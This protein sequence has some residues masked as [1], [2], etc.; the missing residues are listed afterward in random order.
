VG[1][2]H[3]APAA[4]PPGKNRYPLCRKLCGPQGRSGRVRK[5]SSPTGIIS[6]DRPARS[7]ELQHDRHKFSKLRLGV[8]PVCCTFNNV[9]SYVR[10]AMNGVRSLYCGRG[11]T[12]YALKRIS[13]SGRRT[14]VLKCTCL[15]VHEANS[16]FATCG[17]YR[18]M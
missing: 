18:R 8:M 7:D 10:S 16:I 12:F 1:G 9:K 14:V 11:P 4:L 3:H 6:P 2:Q 5:I 15:S 17:T 13:H